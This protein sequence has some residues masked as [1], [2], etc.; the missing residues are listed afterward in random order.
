MQ[1]TQYSPAANTFDVHNVRIRG[2]S[3]TA[4]QFPCTRL[5]CFGVFSTTRVSEKFVHSINDYDLKL[6][7]NARFYEVSVNVVASGAMKLGY[8][9]G[10]HSKENYKIF[11]RVSGNV[12]F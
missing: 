12:G 8:C 4:V 11:F 3:Q 1:V 2:I 7:H 9:A 5:S 10:T 6:V